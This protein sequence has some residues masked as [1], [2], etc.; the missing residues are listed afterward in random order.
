SKRSEYSAGHFTGQIHP[1]KNLPNPSQADY[2]NPIGQAGSGSYG[3]SDSSSTPGTQQS[4]QQG[5]PGDSSPH[6]S[7]EESWSSSSDDE[8]QVYA[9]KSRSRSRMELRFSQ[10][11]YTPTEPSVLQPLLFPH[12]GKRAKGC[13][14]LV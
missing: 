13:R 3:S 4:G 2:Q 8:D 9:F 1:S 6:Q 12:P 7:A 14:P 11:C 10:F 5:A